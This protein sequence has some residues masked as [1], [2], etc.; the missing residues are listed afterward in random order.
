MLIQEAR[1]L[2]QA[3][4][5]AGDAI[6]PM[7]NVG[8]NTWEF[9]TR[10]QPWIDRYLFAPARQRGQVVKH[11][12]LQADHGVDLVGDLTDPAFLRQL[13]AMEFR[14]VLCSNLLE[15]VPNREELAATLVGIVPVGGYLFVSCPYRF[16]Y[17]PDPI[18]T[19]FRPGV[20]ELAALFPG[21]SVERQ[22]IVDGGRMAT[23]LLRDIARRPMA[24]AGAVIRRL[25]RR[26]AED[27]Q[28]ITRGASFL[29][30]FFRR[31]QATCVVLRKR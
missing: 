22:A 13:A 28:V 16:P 9:R 24:F 17:H 25:V 23:L 3:M 12:D 5:E 1:W 7:L 2:G 30:W 19:M 10:H 31:V 26:S 20:E 6:Y 4:A 14:S 8:S 15:H 29:P 11:L 21:T 18:D 27:R